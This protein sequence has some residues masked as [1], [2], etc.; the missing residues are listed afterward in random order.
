[1]NNQLVRKPGGY[2]PELVLALV[3]NNTAKHV[4]LDDD[5]VKIRSIRLKVFAHKGCLCVSCGIEGTQFYKERGAA[6]SRWHLNLYALKDGEEIL[7]TKDHTIPKAA[8]GP[9]T[10]SNLQPMCAK[11]NF[12]K[13]PRYDPLDTGR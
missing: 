9:D 11:C 4:V 10:L 7:M 5:E 6:Q 1:M 8:G 2:E 13:G 3:R 12:A